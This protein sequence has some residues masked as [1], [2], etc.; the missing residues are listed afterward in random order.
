[1][2][3]ETLVVLMTAILMSGCDLLDIKPVG[4][5]IPT[6]LQEYRA[7]LSTAYKTVPSETGKACF[8]SDEMFVHENSYD[9]TSYG[10]I[11]RWDDFSSLEGT[12]PFEWK[13]FYSAMFT[14]NYTIEK[15]GE[16]TEGAEEDIRQLIGECYLLRAYMHFN[17]VNLYGKPYTAPGALATK[18][19][20]LKMNSD[21]NGVLKRHTVEQVYAAV[22]A[23]IDQAE[24]LLN[25]ERWEDQWSYR[26]TTLSVPALRARV[27]LYMGDFKK[28]YDASEALLAQKS[29]LENLNQA[30]YKLPNHYQSVEN[31]TA[32]ELGMT[33]SANQAACASQTLLALYQPGDLRLDAYFKAADKKGNRYSQKGGRDEFRCSF[34]VGEMYL[35]AAE[36]AAQL[37][38]LP[39]A[40]AR[41][42]ALDQ[43]RYTPEAYATRSAA[44]NAMDRAAL[45]EELATERS[46]E[47]A[48]EG[49]RWFDLRRTTRPRLEKVLKG[50]TYVLSQDDKRYTLPIP[51]EAI[52]ANPELAN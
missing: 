39:E 5:V 26:F 49:H 33:S 37:D 24:K 4:M 25:K 44:V 9:Q 3:K 17:L 20:P 18:A 2:K 34:R 22:L 47:L 42:L 36:A 46:R 52:A 48:F 11:E 30:G 38:K 43:N 31:I 27:Y 50:E 45:I 7:L 10:K 41:L 28:A 32:L 14:A 23:D 21:I 15:R 8:R 19:V 12:T 6:T 51:Q 13:N 35:I 1:M 40:K 16:I 29:T